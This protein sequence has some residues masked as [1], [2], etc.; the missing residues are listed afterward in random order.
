MKNKKNKILCHIFDK[1]ILCFNE[2]KVKLFQNIVSW[3]IKMQSNLLSVL[4]IINKTYL[5]S[6]YEM[7]Q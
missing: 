5:L 2:I 1:L 6:V 4:L 3:F 7:N